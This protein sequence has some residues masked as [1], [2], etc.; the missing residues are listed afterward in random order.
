MTDV[1]PINKP[2][3][4]FALD[5]A[6]PLFTDELSQVFY[7]HFKP[8]Y[9]I[10]GIQPLPAPIGLMY[11]MAC[12]KNGNKMTLQIMS[13]P[14][15]ASCIRYNDLPYNDD[16][17]LST[18]IRTMAFETSG[19][20]IDNLYSVAKNF[21][22]KMDQPTLLKDLPS[23]TLHTIIN[24]SRNEIARDTR[25]GVGNVVV[26]TKDIWDSYK[27]FDGITIHNSELYDDSIMLAGNYKDLYTIMVDNRSTSSNTVLTAYKGNFSEMDGGAFY[28]PYKLLLTKTNIKDALHPNGDPITILLSILRACW[29]IQDKKFFRKIVVTSI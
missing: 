7:N 18:H 5:P 20:I 28:C 16:N 3:Q 23:M 9:N 26:M 4:L 15:E 21:N 17:D 2:I 25:R 8:M 19:Y 29:V 24:Q 14:I 12:K 27:E 11:Y 22:I 13:K 1:S 10:I 6:N